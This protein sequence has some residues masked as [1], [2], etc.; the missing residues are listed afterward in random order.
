V[1][2]TPVE[3]RHV[4][5]GRALFGYKRDETERLLDEIADSFEDVWRDRGELADKVEELEKDL[6]EYK[7]REHLL[8]QTLVA[9]ERSAAEA[10]DAA[11]RDAELIVNE[12]HQE[13]RSVAR[14]AQGERDRLVRE[15]HRIE[16]LLRSAL[17]LVEEGRH[18]EDKPAD[19]WPERH[20]TRE[21]EAVEDGS[22]G[23]IVELPPAPEDAPSAEDVAPGRDFH[24]G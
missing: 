18:G 16:T 6:A 2:Y 3:L 9:A 8:T 23:E 4:K 20:D 21:F 1:P 17:G 19:P 14:A 22:A 10:R 12:A 24:W 7:Q 15:A 13:A 5:I 11:R